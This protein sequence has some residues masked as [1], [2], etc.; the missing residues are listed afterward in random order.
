[1]NELARLSEKAVCGI[2]EIG[3]DRKYVASDEAYQTQRRVF[4]KM[5]ELAEEVNKPISVHSRGSQDDVLDLLR[6]YRLEGVLLHWFSGSERQL[7]VALDGGYYVSFGP[8]L[9]YS[10]RTQALARLT[11]P[12]YVLTETDGPVRYGACFENRMAVPSFLVSVVDALA[13]LW[14]TAWH[15]AGSR[16]ETN[17]LR[18]L[19]LD[20]WTEGGERSTTA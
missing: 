4:H 9:V 17:T 16:V 1:M 2:G 20:R 11:P 13:W 12:D 7:R 3:L 6:S 8:T 15:E 10:K 5:L 14:G 18:Y 19:G